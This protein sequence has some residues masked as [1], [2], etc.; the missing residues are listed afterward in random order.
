[1]YL[2]L[3]AEATDWEEVSL[4]TDTSAM[5][6]DRISANPDLSTEVLEVEVTA[7]LVRSSSPRETTPVLGRTMPNTTPVRIPVTIIPDTAMNSF[8]LAVI[9]LEESVLVARPTL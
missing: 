3:K 2:E 6:I 4:T 8:W 7:N 1:M 5:G 9:F